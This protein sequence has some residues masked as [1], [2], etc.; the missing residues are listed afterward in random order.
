MVTTIGRVLATT[1]V[2]ALGVCIFAKLAPIGAGQ[3]LLICFAWALAYFGDEVAPLI[4][5]TTSSSTSQYIDPVIRG[6]GWALLLVVLSL[7][8]LRVA[9][10]WQS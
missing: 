4:G 7:H 9:R 3:M 5:V 10:W 6:I 8:A 1:V 2:A